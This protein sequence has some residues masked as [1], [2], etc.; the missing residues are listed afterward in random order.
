MKALPFARFQEAVYTSNARCREHWPMLA[1][2]MRHMS[3]SLFGRFESKELLRWVLI[4]KG[5]DARGWELRLPLYRPGTVVFSHNESFIILCST[6]DL[7]I[8]KA[9]VEK[10]QVEINYKVTDDDRGH[11]RMITMVQ[12]LR[13][14]GEGKEARDVGGGA[15]LPSA[16]INGH[17]SV[18]QY[19]CKQ[20]LCIH[21][22]LMR[23]FVFQLLFQLV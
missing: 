12:Y 8:V 23:H 18:V 22:L 15:A 9:M 10:T 13:G 19:L 5:I 1:R 17:L 7:D 6:G 21:Q 4:T 14:I 16:A 3:S 20:G 11:H 2:E